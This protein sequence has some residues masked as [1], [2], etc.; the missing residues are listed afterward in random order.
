MKVQI[1]LLAGKNTKVNA[2]YLIYQLNVPYLPHKYLYTC[3]GGGWH[4]I[5]H[6]NLFSYY[7]PNSTNVHKTKEF[8]MWPEC[9]TIPHKN[10]CVMVK[11]LY[12]YS[13]N[14]Y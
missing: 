9:N 4:M 1:I 13:I 11:K 3:S 12:N 8:F 6:I 10:C 2:S 5:P 14:S 7:L